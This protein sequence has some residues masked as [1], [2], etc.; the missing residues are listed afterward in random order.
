MIKWVKS[1]NLASSYSMFCWC[2][3]AGMN[4]CRFGCGICF[5]DRSIYTS[6]APPARISVGLVSASDL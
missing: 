5:D 4:I 6:E 1:T 2:Y 3:T